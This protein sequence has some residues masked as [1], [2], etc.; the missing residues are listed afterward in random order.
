MKKIIK[1]IIIVL[2]CLIVVALLYF[3]IEPLLI[4]K[5][6]AK[7]ENSSKWMARLGDDVPISEVYMPGTHDSGSEFADLAYFSKCQTSGIGAQL[8]DGTR[9]LD[10][11]LQ[12]SGKEGDEE[13]VFCHGFCK[14]RKGIWPWSPVL[15]LEDVLEEC[16]TFLE[17]NPTETIVFA[18]KMEQGDD[19]KAFQELLHTYID[20]DPEHWYLSDSIPRMAECRGRIVLFRRYEDVCGYGKNSGIQLLWADQGG[21]DDTS[22]NAVIEP[23]DTYSLVIQDRYKYAASDKWKAFIA[24][25]E[26][27]SL[28]DSEHLSI[29]FLSTN[30]TPQFGHPYAYAK[31][32]NRNFIAEDFSEYGPSWMILDFSNA[33]MAHQIYDL[34]F[35]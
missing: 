12:V 18:V 4:P 8:E 25:L 16:Y 32:L 19:V 30:G 20:K 31:V 17:A 23:Q 2:V 35:K 6:S 1:K 27:S 13:L 28:M 3:L 21:K 29:S 26:V 10:V 22:L 34:N 11:R 5:S 15:D 14:C 7:V 9:Y 33:S 24:G